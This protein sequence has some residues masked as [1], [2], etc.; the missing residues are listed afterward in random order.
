LSL[1]A[2]NQ[3]FDAFPSATSPPRRGMSPTTALN[4]PARSWKSCI[5]SV[6]N[7]N[8]KSPVSS[9]FGSA[10]MTTISFGFGRARGECRRIGAG[11]GSGVRSAPCSPDECDCLSCLWG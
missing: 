11:P 4:D 7:E 8:W 2:A 6:E 1:T 3:N 5:C 10:A 9:P